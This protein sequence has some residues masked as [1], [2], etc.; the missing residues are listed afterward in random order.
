MVL[1]CSILSGLNAQHAGAAGVDFDTRIPQCVFAANELNVALTELGKKDI[2]V[3]LSINRDESSPEAF[4]IRTADPNRIEVIGSDASGAMYG[5][6]EVAERLRLGL[7]IESGK[8]KPF[9]DKRGIKFNIPLD[10]R[11]PSYDDTGD[12]AQKN[13]EAMW[14]F[15]FWKAYLDDLARYRYNVLSLWATHPFPSIIKLEEY[16]EVALDDVYRISDGVLQPHYKN[17][18][19]EVDFDQP[20][21]T[22]AG[23]ENL[24]R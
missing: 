8:H 7:P 13:I 18:F 6:L 15:E 17:K 22:A 24:D 14:D 1:L 2:R 10:A 5:G 20:G 23:Q 21:T 11:T 19:Q 12:A 16:P 9:V 3:S 4:Q